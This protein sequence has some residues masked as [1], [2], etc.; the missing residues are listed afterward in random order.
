LLFF[1]DELLILNAHLAYL[2][3]AD[4]RWRDSFAAGVAAVN[5]R[6]HGA[7]AAGGSPF[8]GILAFRPDRRSK[9]PTPPLFPSVT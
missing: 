8:S 6:R 5:G 9:W 3:F 7:K 2:L 4:R 1:L